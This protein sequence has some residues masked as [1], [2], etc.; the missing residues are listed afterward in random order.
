MYHFGICEQRENAVN[1]HKYKILILW[2]V[3]LT[4]TKMA[5]FYNS[6]HPYRPNRAAPSPVKLSSTPPHSSRG[7]GLPSGGGA[8]AKSAG[9]LL[10]SF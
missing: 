3:G 4:C 6:S 5:H 7:G 9:G 10:F 1:P 8:G 2:A